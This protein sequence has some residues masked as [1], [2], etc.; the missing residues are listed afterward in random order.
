[1]MTHL[2]YAVGN[3]VIAYNDASFFDMVEDYGDGQLDDRTVQDMTEESVVK[4]T[5]DL[6]DLLDDPPQPTVSST[7]VSSAKKKKRN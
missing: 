3:E 7:T 1:M 4:D 2:Y 6:F 5:A